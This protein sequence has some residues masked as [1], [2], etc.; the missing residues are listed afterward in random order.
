MTVPL[1]RASDPRWLSMSS[2]SSTGGCT[3]IASSANVTRPTGK[4]AGK[5]LRK[6]R[7]A[8]SA[9]AMREGDTSVT[10]ME[11]ETSRVRMTVPWT[12]SSFTRNWNIASPTHTSAPASRATGRARCQAGIAP[13]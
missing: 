9:A 1:A 3:T 13:R 12:A 2:R 8:S 10:S 6:L 4:P 5:V 11:F 7:T